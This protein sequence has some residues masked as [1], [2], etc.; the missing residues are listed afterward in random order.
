MGAAY[1]RFLLYGAKVRHQLCQ[2]LLFLVQCSSHFGFV[3][4]KKPI[5]SYAYSL[6]S[7]GLKL[8]P[9]GLPYL[10]LSPLGYLLRQVYCGDDPVPIVFP[11][12]S[13]RVP[14]HIWRSQTEVQQWYE[15]LEDSE[16]FPSDGPGTLA[17]IGQAA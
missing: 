2:N 13:G 4:Y 12:P 17:R 1:C 5:S 14:P 7:C 11:S 10:F 9:P 8:S 3:P 6:S 15:T 16:R